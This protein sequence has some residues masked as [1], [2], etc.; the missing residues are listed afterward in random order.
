MFF[1]CCSDVS[2]LQPVKELCTF[3]QLHLPSNEEV[4]ML[5]MTGFTVMVNLKP[6]ILYISPGFLIDCYFSM[7]TFSMFRLL[8]F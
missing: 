3:V 1:F 7:S 2:K 6:E 4:G 5:Y 8:K